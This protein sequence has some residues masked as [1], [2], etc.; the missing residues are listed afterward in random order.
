MEGEVSDADSAP[1]VQLAEMLHE[2]FSRFDK[3]V[4]ARSV[5][6]VVKRLLFAS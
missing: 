4:V 3:E 5:F 6:K 2:L 1:M